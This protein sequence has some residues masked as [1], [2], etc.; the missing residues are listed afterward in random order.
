MLYAN[1]IVLIDETHDEVSFKVYLHKPKN[2]RG[3]YWVGLTHNTSST[4]LANFINEDVRKVRFT[5]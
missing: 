4:S 5:L 2:L 1:D 3:L